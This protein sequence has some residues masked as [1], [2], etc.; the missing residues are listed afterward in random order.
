MEVLLRKVFVHYKLHILTF[1]LFKKIYNNKLT[2]DGCIQDSLGFTILLKDNLTSQDEMINL[3]ISS[4]P[5]LLPEL[6]VVLEKILK[7]Q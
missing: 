6:K 4:L 5:S 1:I 2:A 7:I 3:I